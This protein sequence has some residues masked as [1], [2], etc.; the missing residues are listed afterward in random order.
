MIDGEHGRGK[1]ERGRGPTRL[2]RDH[3]TRVRLAARHA[4]H[5]YPGPLG[6]LVAH[7]LTAYAER[8]HGRPPGGLA[9]L[10]VREVL[11]R[12][13]PRGRRPARAG[14][15]EETG[16]SRPTAAGVG[17]PPVSSLRQQVRSGEI[18]T[19]GRAAG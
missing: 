13:A 18:G 8:D 1:D 10:V 2:C 15:G 17:C 5:L 14:R 3:R 6:R 4:E 16:A 19:R 12:P 11:D 9:E 7:E